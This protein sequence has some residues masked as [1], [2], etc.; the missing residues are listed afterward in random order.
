MRRPP[1]RS[2]DIPVDIPVRSRWEITKACLAKHEFKWALG[3]CIPDTALG[4]VRE[5]GSIPDHPAIGFG[6]S[7]TNPSSRAYVLSGGWHSRRTVKYL[8]G[9]RTD[10]KLFHSSTSVLQS[11][12]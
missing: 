5:I 12:A 8:S 6:S 9:Q 10:G 1:G 11:P 4:R 7:I 2:A 3:L